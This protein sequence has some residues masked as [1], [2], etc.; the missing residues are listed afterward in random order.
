MNE[1]NLRNGNKYMVLRQAG[2]KV[3]GRK[4]KAVCPKK[5]DRLPFHQKPATVPSNKTICDTDMLQ[6]CLVIAFLTFCSKF[7]TDLGFFFFKC[8]V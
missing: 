8:K 5:E 1:L 6:K 3:S 2:L 4:K 7:Q